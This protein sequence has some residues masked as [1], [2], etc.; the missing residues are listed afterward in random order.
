MGAHYARPSTDRP[1]VFS[2]CSG[3]FGG[4]QIRLL[5]VVCSDAVWPLLN[6]PFGHRW[7][8]LDRVG[9]AKAP[10]RR[11]ASF[12]IRRELR[13]GMRIFLP[14]L[15][16]SSLKVE[17]DLGWPRALSMWATEWERRRIPLVSRLMERSSGA[18]RQS[19]MANNNSRMASLSTLGCIRGMQTN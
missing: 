13:I 12:S 19:F 15:L 1:S 9:V 10:R 4:Q 5:R 2:H 17:S 11:E 6:A 3:A 14:I 8:P 16:V 7:A 18:E